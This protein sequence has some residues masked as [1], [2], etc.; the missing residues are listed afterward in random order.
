MSDDALHLSVSD[1][2][3]RWSGLYDAYDNPMVL[4]ASLAVDALAVGAAGKAVLEFGCGTGRNLAVLKAAGAA[5]LVG[6]DLSEGMLAQAR[7]RDPAFELRRQDMATRVAEPDASFDLILFC[8]TLEH[9]ADLATPFAEARRLLRPGGTIVVIEIHPFLS[10]NGVGANFEAGGEKIRMPTVPH[11]FADYI[12]AAAGA[13]LAP[14]TCREWLAR[15][16]GGDPASKVFKRGPDAPWIV[17][18]ALSPR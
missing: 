2:Y 12:A 4:A 6:F 1:A 17:Q 3:D 16:V 7:A 18:F 9:V 14:D 11:R 13:G 15:D 10:M 8:L 5:R